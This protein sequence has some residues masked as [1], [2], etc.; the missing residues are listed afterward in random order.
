MPEKSQAGMEFLLTYGWAIIVVL[1]VI[2]ALA[3]FGVLTP[4]RSLPERCQGPMDLL[5]CLEKATIKEGPPGT[6][7][8]EFVIKNQLRNEVIILDADAGHP[9]TAKGDI[10]II[11]DSSGAGP[12]HF[13]AVSGSG[14]N[15]PGDVSTQTIDA[16]GTSVLFGNMAKI[17]M[18]SGTAI[19]EDRFRAEITIFYLNTETGQAHKGYYNII[20][21]SG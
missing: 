5:N 2:S 15:V 19:T 14:G 7:Y 11:E 10:S 12:G 13:N 21:R 1:V 16:N 3:Y 20:G 17:R 8:V 9:A 4:E 6:A 18:Y